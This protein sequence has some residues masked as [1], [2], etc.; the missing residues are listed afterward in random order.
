MTLRL[1]K[2]HKVWHESRLENDRTTPLNGTRWKFNSKL[3]WNIMTQTKSGMS[4]WG[5][6]VVAHLGSE[7]E[8]TYF[9]C[10]RGNLV[11]LV[12]WGYKG[13]TSK[14]F[15]FITV[16][17][18]L[19]KA[20]NNPRKHLKDFTFKVLV[21]QEQWVQWSSSH[22]RHNTAEWG[23]MGIQVL[24]LLSAGCGQAPQNHPV[25]TWQ[26]RHRASECSRWSSLH[27]DGLHTILNIIGESI[28]SRQETL[29]RTQQTFFLQY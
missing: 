28:S 4:R 16:V 21:D 1:V 26:C 7:C 12:T 9:E 29:S 22:P 14:W 8:T 18:A 20:M 10:S 6:T 11:S 15:P 5:I 13:R 3:V 23:A 25:K 27:S 17:M 19:E 24:L 2:V